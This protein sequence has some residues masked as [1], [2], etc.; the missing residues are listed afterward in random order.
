MLVGFMLAKCEKTSTNVSKNGKSNDS[1]K[2]NVSKIVE[3]D[4]FA[5]K[6]STKQVVI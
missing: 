3:K 4:S 2:E 1:Q 6:D 5:K